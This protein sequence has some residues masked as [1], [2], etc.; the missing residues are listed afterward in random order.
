MVLLETGKPMVKSH[1]EAYAKFLCKEGTVR[2]ITGDADGA[3]AAL[4]QTQAI[5]A[6]LTAAD[7]S[8]LGRAVAKL[9][10]L[11]GA[12]EPGDR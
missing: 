5:A 11:L 4:T 6:E 1:R 2:H 8:D 12:Y 10:D 3:R 9:A 7:E